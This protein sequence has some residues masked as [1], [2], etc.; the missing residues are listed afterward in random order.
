MSEQTERRLER[1]FEGSFSN[2][3]LAD[4]LQLEGQ[5][6]FSG[7]I[8]VTSRTRRGR[9]FFQAGEVVHAETGEADGE[10]AV[11]EIIGWPEGTFSIEQNV[12]TL[13]RTITKQ[14]GHLLLDVHHALDEMQVA[15]A[16]E[17]DVG[18]EPAVRSEETREMTVSERVRQIPD[19]SYAVLMTKDGV[20]VDDPSE[21]GEALAAKAL[22]AASML[23]VPL[24][25]HFGLGELLVLSLHSSR[26]QLLIF[27]TRDQ[28][29][30][31]S[32]F[33]GASLDATEAA[34]RQMLAPRAAEKQP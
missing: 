23:A 13:S 34:I 21:Q 10:S 16:K 33:P 5:N 3:L 26:E 24:G 29:F 19:V 20:P 22:Y 30:C 25:G 18:Q 8:S 1:G 28:F 12:S 31:V 4:V 32:V 7:C 6:R 9:L 15:A 2:L 27:H 17:A 11:V 14:L